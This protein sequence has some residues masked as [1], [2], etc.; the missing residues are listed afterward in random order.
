MAVV[1][2][3]A[4]QAQDA[5][6]PYKLPAQHKDAL[7]LD[8]STGLLA[9]AFNSAR[10]HSPF[11]SLEEQVA[12]REENSLVKDLTDYAA[13]FL[14]T[15][16]RLGTS[17]PKSFD[18]SGFTSY[19]FR[20]FGFEISRDSRSQYKEGEKVEKGDLQPGDLMFFSSRSSGKGRVGHVGMVVEVN[21]DGSCKFIH[22]ST[23]HGVVYQNFPDG[24]YYSRHYI[25]AKRIIPED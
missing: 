2:A 25:G 13:K 19:I 15:R 17:G 20:Q 23:K 21:P 24:A 7:A 4:M 11:K 18:C 10:Q 8:A 6:T 9:N 5:K 16:Y 14:G 3:F 1:A 12:Q 22:A